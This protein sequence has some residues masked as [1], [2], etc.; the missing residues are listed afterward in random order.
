MRIA[1]RAKVE[2]QNRQGRAREE[3]DPTAGAKVAA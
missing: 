1:R 2:W 3:A